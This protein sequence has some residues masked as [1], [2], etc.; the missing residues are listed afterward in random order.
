MCGRGGRLSPAPVALYL[1]LFTDFAFK[2]VFGREQNKDILIDFLNSVLEGELQVVGL[3][4]Q[5]CELLS[6][7]RED[8]RVVFD[9]LCEDDRGEINLYI[10]LRAF[11]FK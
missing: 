4:F 6:L 10:T 8:R 9:L 3:E 7:E 11:F 2:W 1:N 5:I